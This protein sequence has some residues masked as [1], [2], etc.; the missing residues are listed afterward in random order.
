M[1]NAFTL[2][3]LATYAFNERD[4]CRCAGEGFRSG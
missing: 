1:W 3:E 2:E 4:A